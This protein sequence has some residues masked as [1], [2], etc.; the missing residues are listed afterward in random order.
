MAEGVLI[1]KQN[2]TVHEVAKGLGVAEGTV[3][4][5][6]QANLL[7]HFRVGRGRGTIRI[8]QE[9]L[10]EYIEQAAVQPHERT[11]IPSGRSRPKQ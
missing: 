5:L 11:A 3:Y 9:D 6:C 2:L 4:A 8:R 7:R 10:D 1:M